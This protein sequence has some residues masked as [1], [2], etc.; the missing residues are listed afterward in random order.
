MVLAL[1]R[2]SHFLA[3]SNDPVYP[4]EFEGSGAAAESKGPTTQHTE[5]VRSRT[6][7]HLQHTK[8]FLV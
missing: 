2:S 5:H 8:H 6:A 3:E 7:Q 4:E 1:W